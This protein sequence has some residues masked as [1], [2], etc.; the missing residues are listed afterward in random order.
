MKKTSLISGIIIGLSMVTVAIAAPPGSPFNLGQTL[1]PACAPGDPNCTVVTPAASG[2]NSDITSLGSGNIGIGTTSAGELLELEKDADVYAKIHATTGNAQKAGIKLQRGAWQTDNFSDWEIED[3]GGE[4]HFNKHSGGVST[5]DMFQFEEDGDFKAT[6]RV[7][8]GVGTGDF[9]AIEIQGDTQWMINAHNSN[10]ALYFRHNNSA[11]PLESYDDMFLTIKNT[12]K[13]GIGVIHPDAFLE[14]DTDTTTFPD[15]WA[16]TLKLTSQQYPSMWL[17]AEGNDEGWVIGNNN[18][19]DLTFMTTNSTSKGNNTLQ[20]S[21]DGKMLLN[22]PSTSDEEFHIGPDTSGSS[23]TAIVLENSGNRYEIHVEDGNDFFIS[24]GDEPDDG[25]TY[26]FSHDGGNSTFGLGKAAV[27]GR[28]ID[29]AGGAHLTTGGT[30]TNASSRSLKKNI[31]NISLAEALEAL[32]GLE[33]VTFEY[34]TEEGENYAGFIAE[35]VPELVASSDRKG[36][37][38]MDIVAVLTKVI[39][40]QEERL[41]DQEQRLEYLEKHL[42]L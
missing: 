23:D 28:L 1:D 27:S 31:E 30:W 22:E 42:G 14:I 11:W 33:P 12:G 41:K 40:D 19:S 6:G 4:I 18:G 32:L 9:A 26:V 2:D 10:D 16:N 15:G 20:L 17:H 3:D 8:V 24:K 5:P 36:L 7:N 29:V 37:A 21:E 35:D 25:G 34:L 13:V 39:Q 38:S